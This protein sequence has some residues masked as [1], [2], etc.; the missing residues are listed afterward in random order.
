MTCD[1]Y[2]IKFLCISANAVQ[3][4]YKVMQITL[5]MCL[6]LFLWMYLISSWE[7]VW[8]D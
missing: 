7:I 2:T 8:I 3:L 6:L 1:M 4:H 5:L